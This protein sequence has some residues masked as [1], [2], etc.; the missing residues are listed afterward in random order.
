MSAKG[1][2]L[3]PKIDAALP[4]VILL[5]GG[6]NAVSV[7]RSLRRQGILVLSLGNRESGLQYSRFCKWIALPG[8]GDIH[9]RWLQWFRGIE[10]KQYAGAAIIACGDDGLEFVLEHRAEL[11][12]NFL[13]Y[14]TNDDVL[15]AML[16]KA[17]TNALAKKAG[18]AT[19]EIWAVKTREDLERIMDVV[20]FPCGLKP[21]ISHEFKRFTDKKLIVAD[22]PTELLL[23]FAGIESYKVE[24]MVTE[25]IPGGDR[26]YCSYYS[27]LDQAGEP[28]F[29]LTKKKLRQ[30]PTGFGT[31][32]FHVTDW[33]PEVA[34]LGL[35]F[36]Q[37]IGLRGFACVEF[38]RDPR[39]GELKLIEVNHRLTEPNEMMLKAGFDFAL[40]IYNRLT[41][42]PLPQLN[43]YR[44]G[45]CLAKP[46]E[47]ML[48]FRELHQKGELGFM[49]WLGTRLYPT[50][51]LYFK[52]WDPAPFVFQ[53]ANYWARQ[54][55]KIK[56]AS[57]KVSNS[58]SVRDLPL[59]KES[60]VA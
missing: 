39:D 51:F 13:V 54:F 60:I 40:L 16:D 42:R 26:G 28:L 57:A 7:A 56:K 44:R 32:T 25:L 37:S 19:P 35:K 31:G 5:G 9:S 38:K 12:E 30:H 50:C 23:A 17:G 45:I 41:K 33:N 18:V 4:P 48:A 21:R 47:D 2:W 11:A 43:S 15:A 46:W 29:H 10:T 22:N 58:F 6:A 20:R 36:F 49:E 55:R 3:K 1:K 52:W 34:A 27:Y 24:M 53:L 59:T 8:P 14:E